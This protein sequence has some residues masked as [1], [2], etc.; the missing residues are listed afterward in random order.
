MLVFQLVYTLQL[1]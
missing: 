1:T